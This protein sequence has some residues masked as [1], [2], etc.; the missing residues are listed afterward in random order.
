MATAIS[1]PFSSHLLNLF[2]SLGLQTSQDGLGFCTN[3]QWHHMVLTL[4]ESWG[5]PCPLDAGRQRW[6]KHPWIGSAGRGNT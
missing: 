1:L 3:P 4:V 5:L 2:L 6:D